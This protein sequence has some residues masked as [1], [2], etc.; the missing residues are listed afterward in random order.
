MDLHPPEWKNYCEASRILGRRGGAGFLGNGGGVR[1]GGKMGLWRWSYMVGRRKGAGRE[2]T[3]IRLTN[4]K[5]SVFVVYF[6]A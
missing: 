3:K 4:I 1:S 6:S 5:C 2:R